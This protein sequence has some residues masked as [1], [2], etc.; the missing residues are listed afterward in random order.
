[1]IFN[2]LQVKF[3]SAVLLMARGT[4]QSG[5]VWTW[6]RWRWWLQGWCDWGTVKDGWWRMECV[7]RIAQR[8]DWWH[9]CRRMAQLRTYGTEG[10]PQMVQHEDE[11]WY[12]PAQAQDERK[13]KLMKG[14]KKRWVGVEREERCVLRG[15]MIV[16]T[17]N[18]HALRFKAWGHATFQTLNERCVLLASE[19][20]FVTLNFAL[21]HDPDLEFSRSNFKKSSISGMGGLTWCKK[22]VNQWD[23]GPTMWPCA[24]TL[25]LD[26][27]S[28]I[29]KKRIPGIGG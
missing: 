17:D 28:Q 26:F 16:N 5:M 23:G 22:D 12:L 20:H 10:G 25:T 21:S 2:S 29:F 4:M 14:R 19:T 7:G 27:H 15:N 11:R 13:E 18:S 6:D 9:G 8:H 1:M 3:H 24:I